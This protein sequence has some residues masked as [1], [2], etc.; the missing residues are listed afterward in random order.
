MRRVALALLLTACGRSGAA[1]PAQQPVVAVAQPPS[2]SNEG[3]PPPRQTPQS[4]AAPP[5]CE[6]PAE[7]GPVIVS[8]D[9]YARRTGAGALRFSDAPTTKE[10]PLEE[11]GL[12][13]SLRRL[14]ELTCNDGS[15]PF[16]GLRQAHVSRAGNVGPGGRCGSIV[17]LYRVPCPEKV[18]DVYVDMYVCRPGGT[19]V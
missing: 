5:S 8:S 6:R 19:D 15:N 1:P 17:D 3:E 12:Q 11:C 7:F 18:Y 2:G 14:V 4:P 9:A 10:L 16:P 13:Q